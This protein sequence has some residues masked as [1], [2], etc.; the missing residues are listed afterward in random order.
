MNSEREKEL[1]KERKEKQK[2]LDDVIERWDWNN[3]LAFIEG[4]K[5]RISEIDKE[6][7]AGK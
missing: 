2:R 3:R 7:G 1:L 5:H 6:L 4:L